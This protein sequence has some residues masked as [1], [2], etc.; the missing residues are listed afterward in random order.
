MVEFSSRQYVN[1]LLPMVRSGRSQSQG[2]CVVVFVQREQKGHTSKKLFVGK[3]SEKN[4]LYTTEAKR[5]L[6]ASI[7]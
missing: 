6:G 7:H 3:I 1:A 5:M 2:L 4:S